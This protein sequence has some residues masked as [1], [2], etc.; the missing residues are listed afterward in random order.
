MRK[1]VP[2]PMMQVPIPLRG[3]PFHKLQYQ[4]GG[5]RPEGGPPDESRSASDF[6]VQDG[7]VR[8]GAVVGW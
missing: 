8:V 2:R 6:F 5:M 1:Y 7:M 4:V 3:I